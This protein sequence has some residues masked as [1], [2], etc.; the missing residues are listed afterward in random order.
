V[1]ARLDGHAD[2]EPP[3]RARQPARWR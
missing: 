3:R 1:A 2:G